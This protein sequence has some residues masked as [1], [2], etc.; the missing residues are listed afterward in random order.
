MRHPRITSFVSSFKQ[1]TATLVACVFCLIMMPSPV[2]ANEKVKD[3]VVKVYN[4]FAWPNFL[5]PWRDGD[6]GSATGSGA[7]ITGNRI[8]TNAHVVAY[9]NFLQVQKNNSP[10]KY[11]AKVAFISHDADLALLTV[12]DPTFFDDIT[13]LKLG[14]LPQPLEQVTLYGYPMGGRSL[15]TTRG[16]LS[17]TEHRRYAHSNAFLLAGQMD[18]AQNSGNS[19]G[20]VIS[21][22][23]IAG[24]AMQSLKGG[25]AENLSYFIPPSV[26]QHFLTDVQDNT[27]DGFINNGFIGQT[28]TNNAMQQFYH[29]NDDEF[30]VLVLHVLSGTP[31]EKS[32]RI[33]D[34]I[35][36]V[37]GYDIANDGTIAFRKNQRTSYKYAFDQYF[38]GQSMPLIVMREGKKIKIDLLLEQSK[39]MPYLSAG[40]QFDHPPEYYIYAGFVFSP[41][42]RSLINAYRRVPSRFNQKTREFSTP[43]KHETVVITG[44]LSAEINQGYTGRP[45]VIEQVNGLA[46]DDFEAFIQ[47]IENNTQEFVIFTSDNKKKIMVKHKEALQSESNI[48]KRYRI[49]AKSF[50]EGNP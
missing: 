47:L 5:K 10:K 31:A 35:L 24:I 28:V 36:N 43:S 48:L 25:G 7:V 22:G 44:K 6:T 21:K 19:G 4:D 41:L 23:K 45:T 14:K 40:M 3:A 20:P 33:N 34:V 1:A 29:L 26:V 37:D 39:R 17:R 9:S 50:I 13:P 16:V 2:L 15:S 18:A 12:N 32:L 46:F 38:S 42:N 11:T 8:I 30:G 27:Y 49:P